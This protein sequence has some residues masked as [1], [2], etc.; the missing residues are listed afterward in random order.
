MVRSTALTCGKGEQST[1]SASAVDNKGLVSRL[2]TK[3]GLSAL[4]ELLENRQS[5]SRQ[6]KCLETDNK[7]LDY[8]KWL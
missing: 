5:E 6:Q 3:E 4:H 7:G 8:R 1:H 2:Q